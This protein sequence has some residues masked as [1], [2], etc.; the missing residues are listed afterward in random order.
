[1][2]EYMSKESYLL[3]DFENTGLGYELYVNKNICKGDYVKL[4]GGEI[5]RVTYVPASSLD[6]YEGES[7]NYKRFSGEYIINFA[8]NIIDLLEEG[9]IIEYCI[10]G[11]EDI[12]GIGT[13]DRYRDFK[14]NKERLVI[15]GTNGVMNLNEIEILSILTHEKYKREC[16]IPT[17]EIKEEES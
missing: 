3:K 1:M 11:W 2:I 10:K 12:T 15:N 16:F 8:N 13:L 17:E 5:V 7:K 6:R 4:L 9:D 14:Q